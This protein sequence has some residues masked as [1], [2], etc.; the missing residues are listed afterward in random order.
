[1]QSLVSFLGNGVV[2]VL[3]KVVGRGVGLVVRGVLQGIGN[4]S[5]PERKRNRD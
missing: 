4:A 1:V 5:L 3:T 2:F